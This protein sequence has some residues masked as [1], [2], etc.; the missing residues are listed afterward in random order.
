MLIGLASLA[1]NHDVET[2]SS[3]QQMLLLCLFFRISQFLAVN[4]GN[5]EMWLISGSQ[6]GTQ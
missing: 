1:A 6:K 5:F 4:F 3:K 2:L